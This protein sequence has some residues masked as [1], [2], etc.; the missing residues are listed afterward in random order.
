MD[1]VKSDKDILSDS[2]DAV[3]SLNNSAVDLN[4]NPTEESKTEKDVN[5]K[6]DVIPMNE[7]NKTKLDVPK[8]DEK[9]TLPQKASPKKAPIKS[10]QKTKTLG[11]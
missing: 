5:T 11:K 3:F 1:D 9:K 2:F 7:K 8:K 10:A 6:P 4:P